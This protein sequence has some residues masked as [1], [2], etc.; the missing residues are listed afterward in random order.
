MI[1]PK[2]FPLNMKKSPNNIHKTPFPRVIQIKRLSN[3]ALL[4]VCHPGLQYQLI[5][6]M[7]S[8]NK[9]IGWGIVFGK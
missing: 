8:Q 3:D 6:G 5:A 1:Y 7:P 4:P 9:M 2:P